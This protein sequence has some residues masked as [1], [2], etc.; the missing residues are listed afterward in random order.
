M[1]CVRCGMDLTHEFQ[2][3]YINNEGPLCGSCYG[4]ASITPKAPW[5]CPRCGKVNGPHVDTCSCNPI[6]NPPT[7]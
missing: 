7:I 4:F 2:M 5:I 1:N 3:G 6:L